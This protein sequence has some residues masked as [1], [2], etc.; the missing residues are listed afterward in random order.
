MSG[1]EKPVV[2]VTGASSGIGK[3]FALRLLREGYRVYGAARRV[4]R[5]AD[6]ESAGGVA[7]EMDVTDDAAMTT[8]IDR[9]IRDEGRIDV[10][11]NNAGYGQMGA[12]EDVPM[13]VARRQMEVNL[14]GVARLTQLVLPHMRA[15]KSGR[16]VNISTI[17]GKF[18]GPLGG[19]Y[20][21]SKHALEGYSDTLRM[22]VRQFGIDVVVIEPGG[23]E[24]EWGPIA[25]GSAEQYSGQ[26]AYGPLVKVMM[27]SPI[28]KRTMPPPQ[29]ITDL[30]LKALKSKRP[31]ARYHG[32]YM[33]GP[34]LFLKWLLPDQM[35][36]WVLMKTMQ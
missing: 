5:M 26:G 27:N 12:L 20:Y 11:V 19:W 22:E 36:D 17:G 25:F 32:G 6:I 1:K 2:L 29:V 21:A 13:D 10:L 15:Q 4:E 33:A 34:I 8:A 35:M 3:D 14:I 9:I 24:T 31:R 30:L 16:I 18:A 28:L 7:L 23:I